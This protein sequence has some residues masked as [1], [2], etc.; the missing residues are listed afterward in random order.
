[1]SKPK[2]TRKD[3][4]Q[5]LRSGAALDAPR[6]REVTGRI[7]GALAAA[8]ATGRTVE[9]RGL[10]SLEVREHG[11]RRGKNPRTGEAVAVPPRRYVLFYPGSA[12]KAAMREAGPEA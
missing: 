4:Q 12:L 8:L 1:M 3:L 2:F 9:L 11:E 5:L 6:A 7:I 10:G